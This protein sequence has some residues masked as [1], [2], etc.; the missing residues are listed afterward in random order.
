MGSAEGDLL[1]LG[2]IL[3]WVAVQLELSNVADWKVLL[4][5]KLGGVKRVEIE[6]VRHRLGHYLDSKLPL[7]ERTS[8][9][10]GPQIVTVEIRVLT[11]DLQSLVPHEGMHSQFR[12]EVELDQVAFALGVLQ[13]VGVD[14]KALHHAVRARDS[15]VGLSPHEHV[16]GLLVEVLEVPEV[17]V[18]SLSLRNAVVGLWLAGMDDVHELDGILNEEDRNVIAHDVPVTLFG[19]EL[20]RESSN[21]SDGVCTSSAT[22][23]GRETEEERSFTRRIGHNSS[24]G[25]V[26]CALEESECTEGTSS[27]GV[28]N[29]LWDAL[30]VK[31]MNLRI[32]NGR[33]LIKKLGIY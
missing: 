1:G 24:F 22:Q 7:G 6:V 8:L 18:S 10:R 21:I 23:H 25:H 15:A 26:L 32:V 14:T 9:D 11:S 28:D 2:E 13:R 17:V 29:T 5:P 12:S 31:T 16:G 30:V 33:A 19:V 4:R 20:H 27:T 3:I